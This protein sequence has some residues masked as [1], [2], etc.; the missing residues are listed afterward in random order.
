M[1]MVQQAIEVG[2]PLHAVY[3][4]LAAFE[5]YPRF[6]AGVERVTPVGPDETHWVMQVGGHRRE[7]DARI[8]ERSLDERVSWAT[9]VGPRLAETIT[10]R[11]M[12]ETRTQVV[13]QLEADAAFLP[14][15]D[16]HAQDTLSQRLKDDLVALKGL[17]ESAGGTQIGVSSKLLSG[18]AR[19]LPP[20]RRIGGHGPM[21]PAAARPD[22]TRGGPAGSGTGSAPMGGRTAAKDIWGDGMINEV[23]RGSAHDL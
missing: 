18:P 16:R 21:P 11:P 2:A 23:S 13:A 15:S 4:E 5:N 10:L 17:I 14:P 9:T 22:R 20:S 3:E 19:T 1:S 7:F 6:M 8:I 12:G